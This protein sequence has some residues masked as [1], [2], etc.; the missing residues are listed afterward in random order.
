MLHPG[1]VLSRD[2]LL[3]AVWGWNDPSAG[4]TVDTRIAE[5]RRALNDHPEAPNYIETLIG[6]GYCFIGRVEVEDQKL[7]TVLQT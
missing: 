7:Q 6:Q 2:R 4:R 3:D 1:E 5:L